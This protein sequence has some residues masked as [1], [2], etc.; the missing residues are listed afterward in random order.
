MARSLLIT[1]LP[2]LLP[3]AMYFAWRAVY[4]TAR[5]PAWAEQVPWVSLL[6]IGLV[7]AA[8]TLGVFRLQTGAPPDSQYVPPHYENGTL[9]PGH[10]K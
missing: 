2:L 7:L 3:L 8:L 1:L 10:F 6:S 4:G 9:I 5:L